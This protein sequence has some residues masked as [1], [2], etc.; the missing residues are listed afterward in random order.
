MIAIVL[1]GAYAIVLPAAYWLTKLILSIDNAG[2]L[3]ARERQ[4]LAARDTLT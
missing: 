3:A 2:D 1:L 4:Y